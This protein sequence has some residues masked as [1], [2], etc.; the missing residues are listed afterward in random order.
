M[1]VKPN[2]LH[3]DCHIGILFVPTL[4]P[5]CRASRVCSAPSR[6]PLKLQ[7]GPS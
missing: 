5:A 3:M 7:L 6:Q 2:V 4:P 1:C